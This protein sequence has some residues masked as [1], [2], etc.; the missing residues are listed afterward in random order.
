MPDPIDSLVLSH[1][2]ITGAILFSLGL[3]G[4]IARR[5]LIIMFLCTELM[6]QGVVVTLVAF[7]RFHL[8]VTGQTFVIFVLT[9]AA[10]EAALALGLVVL[11]FRRR[12]TLDAQAWATMQ[13]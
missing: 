1:F 4:F 9:I 8:N 10:A 12:R 7:S 13:G 3:I 6:F 2:L 11:L 5:N